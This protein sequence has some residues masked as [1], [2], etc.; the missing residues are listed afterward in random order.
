M[1]LLPITA[2]AQFNLTPNGFITDDDKNYYV[3]EVNGTQEEL[4]K[5]MKTVITE[6]M[7]SADDATSFNEYD[8]I[9]LRMNVDKITYYKWA[10]FNY[11]WDCTA[12]FKIL[13]KD[14]KIRF[15]APTFD[16]RFQKWLGCGKR[17]PFTGANY[18]FNSTKNNEPYYK[19][20]V[21]EIENR[22]N[23]IINNLIDKV[24]D[25]NSVEEW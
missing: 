17:N 22:I 13:F 5:K 12:S 25:N 3:V 4:F 16:K 10:G 24:K 15:N 2:F 11:Y 19:E 1:A 23:G 8:I 18:L 7:V 21:V 6:I 14:G 9:S 20:S